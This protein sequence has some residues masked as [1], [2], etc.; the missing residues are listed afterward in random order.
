MEQDRIERAPEEERSIRNGKPVFPEASRGSVT[1]LVTNI[2]KG[3]RNFGFSLEIVPFTALFY[4]PPCH[5][6]VK[7]MRAPLKL[8]T[9]RSLV[10]G[11]SRFLKSRFYRE[12]HPTESLF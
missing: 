3:I 1:P 10:R 5:G 12:C 6:I 9:E 11:L 2:M 8:R 7:P 4:D